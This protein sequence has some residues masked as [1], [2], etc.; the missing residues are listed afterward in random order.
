MSL[1]LYLL[2]TLDIR[3]GDRPLPRPPTLK[4]QSLLAY[5]VRHRDRPQP[6][7]RLVGLFWGDRPER[8]ARRSLATALWHIRHRCLPDAALILSD[9]HT[10]QFDPQTDL[11]LDVDAFE[12]LASRDDLISLQSAV[13]LYR[14]DFL[15]GFYDDWVIGERYRLE[16]LL[17]EVLERL[18]AG[19]EAQGEYEAALATALR[20]L[21]HD[22]LRE[23]AH[24]LAMRAYSRLGQRNAALSQYRRCR[25]IIREELGTEPM[26]ET[27]ELY[28]AILAG[29]LEVE[30]ASEVRP[31]PVESL[32]E[33]P[34]GPGRTPLDATAAT[35]L[36]GREEELAFLHRCWQAAQAG[37]GRLVL[38]GGQAGIGTSSLIRAF[39]D[40]LRWQGI[41]VLWGRCYEFERLLPYQPFAEVLQ[42]AL[43][44]L[45]STV[46]R[47]LPAWVLGEV[48]RLA[49][50]IL[51]QPALVEGEGQPDL[52]VPPAIRSDQERG[53]LF[54]GV[55]RFL[56]QLAAHG[57][58]LIVL[59]DLHWATETSLQ[60]VHFLARHLA[61]HPVLLIGSYRA[62]EVE[63]QH[64]LW[65]IRQQLRR[66]GLV[67]S[68]HLPPLSP[69]AVEEMV[70]EMSE[71]GEAT[72]PLARRLHR[73]TGG[74]PFFIIEIVKELFETG[75][76][77]LERGVWQGDFARVNEEDL[78]LPDSVSEVIGRR[79]RRLDDASRTALQQAA[80]LGREFDFDVLNAL[81]G[82]A[83]EATLEVVDGLLRHG[84]I[85]EGTG[86]MGRDYAFS[87]HLIQEVIYAGI[88]R[89]RRQHI[90][91]QAAEV[92]QTLYGA[93]AAALAGELAFHFRQGR[94]PA[95]ALAWTES[96]A[97]QAR[98][99]YAIEEAVAYYGQAQRLAREVRAGPK[100]ESDLL[101]KR[102]E[103]LLLN[104]AFN[105]ARADLEEALALASEAGDRQL[106]AEVLLVSADVHAQANAFNATIR[107]AREALALAEACQD[108]R[109][110]GIALRFEGEGLY[111]QGQ[112][113]QARVCAE[114]AC[115]LLARAG[116]VEEE[117]WA[118]FLLAT[119]YLDLLG[120]FDAART[121][122]ALAH[123]LF[124]RSGC[125]HGRILADHLVGNVY[126]RSG[127]LQSAVEQHARALADARRIGYGVQEAVELAHLAINQS[128]LG[129]LEAA[130]QSA[131][132]C[133]EISRRLG[134]A[135]W[136]A[137]GAY[138]LGHV[139]YERG[140]LKA[141]RTLMEE[142]LSPADR[143]NYRVGIAFIKSHL[144]RLHRLLG[145]PSDLAQALAHAEDA[146]QIA[147]QVGS[148]VEQIRALSNRAMAHLALG[149]PAEALSLSEQAVA[150][151]RETSAQ[152]FS[153]EMLFY[154]AQVLHANG[155]AEEAQRY[156]DEAH[157]DL[158]AK[159]E[160]IRDPDLKQSFLKNVRINR[161]IL[162]AF[163]RWGVI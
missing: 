11:W 45:T 44:T 53:R 73:K 109:L 127:D 16:A 77:R 108:E 47:N 117:G 76:L 160:K 13:A 66:Q 113:Q 145:T 148:P 130:E 155:C 111:F 68:L 23:D 15:E 56:A 105:A 139:A 135:L 142:A 80:V 3:D 118:H 93:E 54:N 149:D 8:K 134:M 115:A 141:A 137:Y 78:P 72:L 162:A 156:L 120:E 49:P 157:A 153:P 129:D 28:R 70:A 103:A 85:V 64:P 69:A 46:V 94:R 110:A 50:E 102:A 99:R 43:P 131:R 75:V 30:R 59:E 119:T 100:R 52:P 26:I 125:V 126:A 33:T 6:R 51:E 136:E 57:A 55:A 19:Q 98:Q 89:R 144:S 40:H 35:P 87:H 41:R 12:V 42:A 96:A 34:P 91:A 22:P 37:R 48:A 71:M 121:H 97:D 147:C 151:A 95:E 58:L 81:R 36:V 161:E 2:G 146:Y 86:Q 132:A 104:G 61:D 5:L 17:F 4:S 20:L 29:S 74:N 143:V 112:S 152:D 67:E 10:V 123:E 84:L 88:P 83:E 116:A 65:G 140:N 24:R 90:H 138:W 124:E 1:R 14:G 92:M 31:A 18:M 150:L 158:V 21:H 79:V 38:I 62:G 159:A 25:E 128:L 32:P 133:R 82:E 106:Q 27:T 7:D 63:T 101:R 60:L 107:A 163:E 122:L 39:A 114:R 9:A 154:H